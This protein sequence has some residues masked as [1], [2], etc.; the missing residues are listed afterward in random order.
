MLGVGLL[1]EKREKVDW[2]R[3]RVYWGTTSFVVISLFFNAHSTHYHLATLLLP[4][5]TTQR[6]LFNHRKHNDAWRRR[7][8]I[9]DPY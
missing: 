2:I 3:V 9:F 7:T 1:V 6:Y 4:V 8:F 5:T